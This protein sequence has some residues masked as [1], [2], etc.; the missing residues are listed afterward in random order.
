MVEYDCT[1]NTIKQVVSYPNGVEPYYHTVCKYKDDTIVIA[2]GHNGVVVTFNVNTKIFSEPVS[3]SKV[4]SWC[5]AIAVQEYIHIFHGDENKKSEYVVYS[6]NERTANTSK[7][8]SSS[9]PMS[10]VALT[11]GEGNTYYKFGGFD[12]ST[13]KP[14]NSF[15]IGSLTNNDGAKPLI[16]RQT[17]KFTLKK[18]PS[19]FGYVQRGPFIVILGGWS[20]D[21]EDTVSILDLR[22]DSGWRPSAFTCPLKTRYIATLDND[23]NIHLFTW[24]ASHKK[25][26][27]VGL[28]TLGI[29]LEDRDDEK[30]SDEDDD[31]VSLVFRFKTLTCLQDVA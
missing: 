29:E 24:G 11:K 15:F 1:T 13:G 10:G 16:W 8:E 31:G 14:V 22:D 28:K 4:G 18:P 20:G 23:E 5:S 9:V 30:G 3:F 27:S 2:D 25:H 6:M 19:H 7:D 12:Y 17:N 21:W 26:F